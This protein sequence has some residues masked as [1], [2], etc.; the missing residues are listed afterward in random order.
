MLMTFRSWF[1]SRTT[2]DLMR[3]R[4]ERAEAAARFHLQECEAR[5]NAAEARAARAEQA[6]QTAHAQSIAAI[7]EGRKAMNEASSLAKAA[8]ATMF[9]VVEPEGAVAKGT[10][11]GENDR[12][13]ARHIRERQS[14]ER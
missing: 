13:A 2:F 8:A 10:S 3:E 5:V 1:V 11:I 12:L 7:A 4:A 9:G 14:N 6:L